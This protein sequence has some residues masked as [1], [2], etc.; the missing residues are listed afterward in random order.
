MLSQQEARLLDHNHIGTEHI[1]LGLIEE[2][3]GVGAR[4][5]ESL[6][7][8]LDVTRSLVVEITGRGR[9][10]PSGHIPFTPRAKKVLELSLREALQLGHN[11]IGTEH[12]LLGLV[13]EGDGVAAQI[14]EQ[15]GADLRT[16]RQ[17]VIH[18]L[19]GADGATD[20]TLADRYPRLE[21]FN[22]EPEPR[23]ARSGSP[24]ELR[25]GFSR[26]VRRGDRIE[27]AGTAPVPPEG[28]EVAATAYDQMMR[29]GEIALDALRVLG[30]DA[31]HV[32]RTV[33]YITDA[34]EAD[35]VG[36]AHGEL[37]G[38]AAPAATMVVVAGLLE[39][40][41]KVEIEVSAQLFL[42]T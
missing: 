25:Y 7:I 3:E 30:G 26:G 13:G 33:M 41:W 34:A 2:G 23:I 35:E 32:I 24:Y 4:A 37:F 27:I 10:A 29:C 8:E 15:L 31:R 18:L 1:L 17:S 5:L 9:K 39:P 20:M 19:S 36:R 12:V 11:Y 38:E 21:S 6:G 28:E 16:V 42:A 40:A 14:L 22:P